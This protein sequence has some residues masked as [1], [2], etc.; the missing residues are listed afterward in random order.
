MLQDPSRWVRAGFVLKPERPTT[1]KRTPWATGRD[2]RA[3][4]D[5]VPI[6][7]LVTQ[8]YARSAQ[9]RLGDGLRER[10]ALPSP[11]RGK[12]GL[13]LVID[14][15]VGAP[16]RPRTGEA[17]SEVT[18]KCGR[19]DVALHPGGTRVDSAG[20]L[21]GGGGRKEVWLCGC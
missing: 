2:A 10:S 18:R 7:L 3:G 20:I 17:R 14:C 15:T 11:R 6:G 12:L 1:W 16:R 5:C 21:R 8:L 4:G 13:Q 19:A 9:C